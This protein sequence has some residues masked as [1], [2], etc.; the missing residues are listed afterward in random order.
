MIC[1]KCG[2]KLKSKELFCTECGNYNNEDEEDDLEE[3]LLDEAFNEEYEELTFDD[4]DEEVEDNSEEIDED[5][6]SITDNLIKKYIGEDYNS[7]N[8]N[9]MNIFAIFLSWLYC[10][11][12]KLY[13]I[14]ILGMVLTG[15]VIKYYY[16]YLIIYIVV[17]MLLNGITFNTIYLMIVRKRVNRLK[18]KKMTYKEQQEICEKKGGVNVF[19]P[20]LV[21]AIF[22]AI[23]IITS[24][25]TLDNNRDK[26]FK[27]NSENQANCKSMS[28]QAY[29]I[30]KS[31]KIE[32]EITQVA[33]NITTND[34]TKSYN[35]YLK[36]RDIMGEKYLYFEND[37]T[38]LTLLGNTEY[39][40]LLEAKEKDKTITKEEAIILSNSNNL[41]DKYE[42]I[43]ENSAYEKR[44]SEVGT[45]TKA[46]EN[47]VF[48]KKDITD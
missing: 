38:K 26:F 19:L 15:I 9:I 2:R 41:K 42:K 23:V 4:N 44:I 28:K 17:V 25:K 12:R 14:G 22:L 34:K 13:L 35:I 7:I 36:M 6:S 31:T 46:R 24:F 33:C 10:I 29:T 1:K 45:N 48:S 16:K 27:E 8:N 40:S 21:F 3:N 37:K 43:V 32:G 47:Y 5:T 20:L 11:Y 18:K 39:I 30:L